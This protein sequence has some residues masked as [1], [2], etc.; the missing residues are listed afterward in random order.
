MN[1]LQL[2]LQQQKYKLYIDTKS[3]KLVESTTISIPN[4]DP[5][6]FL[7]VSKTD[8]ILFPMKPPNLFDA[9]H[10]IIEDQ[11]EDSKSRYKNNNRGGTKVE[12][13]TETINHPPD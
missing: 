11:D 1:P 4:K 5:F 8:N 3:V 6:S 7:R 9:A 10:T 12:T 13:T 2:Y